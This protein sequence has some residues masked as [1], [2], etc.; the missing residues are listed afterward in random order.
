M[1]NRFDRH[2]LHPGWA[3]AFTLAYV[4]FAYLALAYTQDSAGIAHVWP[5]SGIAVAGLLV[6]RGRGRALLMA[7][8]ALGSLAANTSFGTPFAT[9]AWFTLANLLE[10][11]VAARIACTGDARCLSFDRPQWVARYAIAAVLATILS[12]CVA[13]SMAGRFAS[14]E[15]MF[16]WFATVL[17][18]IL[19]VGPATIYVVRFFADRTERATMD[20]GTSMRLLGVV[21]CAAAFSAITFGQNE[22]P[23]LFLPFAVVGFATFMLGVGGALVATIAIATI[24]SIYSSFGSGPVTF[25]DGAVEQTF[26]FQFYLLV[27]LVSALPTAS[28]V[29]DRRRRTREVQDSRDLL[30]AAAEIAHV[31]HWRYDLSTRS[32]QW[33]DEMY[34]IY[35]IAQDT[36]VSI[37]TAVKACDPH[38]AVRI[39]EL[40]DQAA[41]TLRPFDFDVRIM[42]PDGS[43]RHVSGR[44]HVESEGTR[45]T[46]LFGV[47]VDVTEREELMEQLRAARA[48]AEEEARQATRAAETD[49]LTGVANRRKAMNFL[50]ALRRRAEQGDMGFAIVLIDADH[51]KSINDGFGH[52]VGDEVLKRIAQACSDCLRPTDL[53]ARFGGEE[54]LAILPGAGAEQARTVAE[55]LRERVA[56]IRLDESGLEEISISLGVALWREGADETWLLQAADTALYEAKAAGRNRFAMAA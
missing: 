9:A 46:A 38:D 13:V 52:A 17:L 44:G 30:E 43:A 28:M 4:A 19:L 48:V 42:R 54:F 2:P 31:G 15:F 11:F 18:G 26:F 23:L 49:P 27:L 5:S 25:I 10:A 40:L 56:A 36:P 53:F 37:D 6:L 1:G 34:R 32:L 50:S 21:A 12:S 47:L 45:A 14:L 20:R 22:Y 55:R 24:G 39:S 7:G 8:V 35:G 51:F 16:S 41:L 33:S 3:L 29:A